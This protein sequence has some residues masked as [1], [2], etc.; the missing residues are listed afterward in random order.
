[1]KKKL[2]II[3]P[4]ILVVLV[5][6]FAAL[7]IFTDLFKSSETLFYKYLAKTFESENNYSYDNFLEDVKFYNEKA[8]TSETNIS[9]EVD[10]EDSEDVDFLNDLKLST[11][12][13]QSPK[14]EDVQ[15]KLSIAYKNDT[16]AELELLKSK[17]NYGIKCEDL[18][19]DYIY[20]E[21]ES[22]KDLAEK[23]GIDSE[24]IPDSIS[25]I[26]IY[27]LLY[28]SPDF[29]KDFSKEYLKSLQEELDKDKFST[30]KGVKVEVNGEKIEADAHTLTLKAEDFYNILISLLETLEDDDATLDL[31]IEK[32]DLVFA[33]Y[34]DLSISKDDLKSS[35]SD[36]IEELEYN[37]EY[38]SDA[39]GKIKLTVYESKGKTVKVAF[40]ADTNVI[41]LDITKKS[42][43]GIIG[44][45]CT[46]DDEEVVSI[47]NEY[48]IKD[49][50]TTGSITFASSSSSSLDYSSTDS[51]QNFAINYE[52]VNSDKQQKLVANIEI[53]DEEDMVFELG[54][55]IQGDNLDERPTDY[56]YNYYIK[57]ADSENSMKIN[58]DGSIKYSDSVEIPEITGV[59]LNTATDADLEKVQTDINTN[60]NKYIDELLEKFDMTRSDMGLPEGEI[61]FFGDSTSV[62]PENDFDVDL[63]DAS[64][65]NVPNS[66]VTL[67]VNNTEI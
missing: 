44:I 37:K 64:T 32:F 63:E 38:Y 41:S 51:T 19:K 7:Y 35:L 46:S 66:S 33:D 42:D 54:F 53:P 57:F 67:D 23:F 48:K 39:S 59:C 61:N 8:C 34:E 5:A 45:Y 10:F 50:T 3:I 49:D 6:T 28:I 21:N 52:Y 24:Y 58:L 2:L 62:T 55:D 15:T 43:E 20:V 4:I 47:K 30:E 56:K 1:M 11:V 60:G 12:T 31:V 65:I 26:D 40:K 16:L 9:L 22:L 29:R 17:N 18:Y 14:Q 36:I 27:E 25:T 13:V